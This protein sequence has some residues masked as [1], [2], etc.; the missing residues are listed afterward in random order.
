MMVLVSYGLNTKTVE[1]DAEV[2]ERL[3][4]LKATG[5]IAT[6]FLK[7]LLPDGGIDLY[8]SVRDAYFKHQPVIVETSH[9]GK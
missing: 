2:T 9:A 6:L 3:T 7:G 5:F 4:G 1:V 8:V